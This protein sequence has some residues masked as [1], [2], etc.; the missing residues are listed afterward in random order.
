[1]QIGVGLCFTV[2]YFVMFRFMI[3]KFDFKTPG[4]E[5]DGGE[6]KLYSKA[7]Y[8]AAKAAEKDGGA[9]APAADGDLYAPRAAGFLELLGGAENITTVN[10]C[11]TR[12]RVSAPRMQTS[13]MQALWVWSARARHS[14]SS[15]AWTFPRFAS[16]SRPW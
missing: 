12:L 11:A 13:R 4:R 5:E 7:E 2:L 16:V 3:L 14:R 1:M 6:T 15:S 10:N 8:K 9:A